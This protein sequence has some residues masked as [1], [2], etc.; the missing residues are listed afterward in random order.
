MNSHLKAHLQVILAT[1]II[2]GSFIATAD[3]SDQLHPIS[4]NLMRFS[5]AALV[6]V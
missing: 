1:L 6:L 5:V 2:A 3:I 4:L